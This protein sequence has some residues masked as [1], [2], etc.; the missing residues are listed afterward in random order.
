MNQLVCVGFFVNFVGV[1]FL[2]LI[3]GCETKFLSIIFDTIA[4]FYFIYTFHFEKKKYFIILFHC[5]YL[6]VGQ[7]G[8]NVQYVCL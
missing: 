7:M 2:S 1:Y 4:S 5:L 3:T 8:D 6:Y